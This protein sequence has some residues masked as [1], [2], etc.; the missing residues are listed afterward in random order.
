[1]A[2]ETAPRGQA[3]TKGGQIACLCNFHGFTTMEESQTANLCIVH[4]LTATEA[5]QTT[6]TS[7]DQNLKLKVVVATVMV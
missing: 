7:N 1:L 4:G 5:D 3:I 2:V 6:S